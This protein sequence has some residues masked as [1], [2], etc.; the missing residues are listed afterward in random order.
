MTV[1][2]NRLVDELQDSAGR[3]VFNGWSTGAVSAATHHGG[4]HPATMN[5]IFMSVGAQAIDRFLKPVTMVGFPDELVP[6]WLGGG[7]TA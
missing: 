4:P 5:P 6:A 1:V 3:I 7:T 2:V